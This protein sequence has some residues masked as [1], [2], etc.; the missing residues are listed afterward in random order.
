[1]LKTCSSRTHPDQ[2]VAKFIRSFSCAHFSFSA[3]S[4]VK[5]EAFS[6]S[7]ISGCFKVSSSFS[8]SLRLATKAIDM[9]TGTLFRASRG[10]LSGGLTRPFCQGQLDAIN[11]QK[12]INNLYSFSCFIIRSALFL[13]IYFIYDLAQFI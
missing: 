10:G 6:G 7:A 4:F 1:M 2:A 12:T 3:S 11:Y 5:A 9:L 13:T 8:I